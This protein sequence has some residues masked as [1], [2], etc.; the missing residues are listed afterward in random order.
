MSY[1]YSS[2]YQRSFTKNDNYIWNTVINHNYKSLDSFLKTS[3]QLTCPNI[4]Y[5]LALSCLVNPNIDSFIETKRVIDKYIG[6][7]TFTSYLFVYPI[8]QGSDW[9][10][11][12]VGFN[13]T[14]NSFVP[15]KIKLDKG[16]TE[17]FI[18]N[19]KSYIVKYHNNINNYNKVN[20]CLEQL[21]VQDNYGKRIVKVKYDKNAPPINGLFN[22]N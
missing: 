8:Y 3:G 15:G 6:R 4:N 16:Y 21:L 7:L 2:Y 5:A 18:N 17:Q 14:H 11:K 10:K 19:L 9:V 1:I 20:D 22:Y 13:Y 12:I